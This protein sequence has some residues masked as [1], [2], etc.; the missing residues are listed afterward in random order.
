MS[1]LI[2]WKDLLKQ[3]YQQKQFYS[4]LYTEDI[5]NEAMSMQKKN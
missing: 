1:T 2:V 5:T 4:S 3:N